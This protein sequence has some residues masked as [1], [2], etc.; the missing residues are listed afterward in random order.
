MESNDYKIAVG[1]TIGGTQEFIAIVLKK[2][3]PYLKKQLKK[4]TSTTLRTKLGIHLSYGLCYMNRWEIKTSGTWGISYIREA[5]RWEKLFLLKAGI[6]SSVD[7]EV[8]DLIRKEIYGES[9]NN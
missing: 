2:D 8:L 3:Y 1:S 7:R 9:Y 6:T 4:C 5:T